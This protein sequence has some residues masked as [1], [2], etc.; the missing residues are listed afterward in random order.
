ML[1][2]ETVAVQFAC[3]HI[4]VMAGERGWEAQQVYED[5]KHGTCPHCGQFGQVWVSTVLVSEVER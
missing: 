1:L 5:W 4:V 3:L 2:Q